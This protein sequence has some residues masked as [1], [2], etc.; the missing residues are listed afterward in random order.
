MVFVWLQCDEDSHA[1]YNR[2]IAQQHV[3]NLELKLENEGLRKE[4]EEERRMNR[5]LSTAAA[6]D[7][8]FFLYADL[9][10]CIAI[11]AKIQNGVEDEL[12]LKQFQPNYSNIPSQSMRRLKNLRS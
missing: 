5:F 6:N 9:E 4:L 10:T 1:D 3:D 8:F 2:L 7:D 12:V 11:S